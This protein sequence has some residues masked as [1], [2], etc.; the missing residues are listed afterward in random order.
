MNQKIKRDIKD[1][2][3]CLQCGEK[4][5][6]FQKGG[7]AGIIEGVIFLF[8][9][10]VVFLKDLLFGLI[11]MAVSGIITVIRLN[12]NKK[13]CPSCESVNIV[14]STSPIAQELVKSR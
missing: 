9:L 14:P 5:I 6:P 4:I 7:Q 10:A 13:C 11:L 8:G 2:W 12:D 1:T 3:L